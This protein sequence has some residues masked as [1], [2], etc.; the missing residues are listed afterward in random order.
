MRAPEASYYP[1][2]SH[3]TPRMAD[4]LFCA[5]VTNTVYVDYLSTRSDVLLT[6]RRKTNR[7][8]ARR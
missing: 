8:P 1:A 7:P 2:W 4:D 5:H 6:M 3:S